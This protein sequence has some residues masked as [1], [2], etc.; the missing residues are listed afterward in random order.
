MWCRGYPD[1][2]FQVMRHTPKEELKDMQVFDSILGFAS[3]SPFDEALHDLGHADRVEYLTISPDDTARRRMRITTDKGTDCAIALSRDQQLSDGAILK[4][5]DDGAIVVRLAQRQWLTLEARDHAAA[6]ELG[7]FA[8][9]LH[10]K[11]EFDGEILRVALEGPRQTYLDRLELLIQEGKAK[12][13]A[14]D[15]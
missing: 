8:G 14:H 11:V 10:W 3:E 13:L 6:L 15:A 2:V 12:V 5:G 7:Y 4:L 9:N 1:R